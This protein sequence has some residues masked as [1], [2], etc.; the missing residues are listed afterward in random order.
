MKQNSHEYKVKNSHQ[1]G[2][3]GGTYA[4]IFLKKHYKILLL[5]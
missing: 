2:I 4:V 5:D 3:P 1:K